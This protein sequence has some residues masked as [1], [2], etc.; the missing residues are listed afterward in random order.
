[1]SSFSIYE[2]TLTPIGNRVL[3]TD[4]EFGEQ[5][6][7][8]GIILPSDDGQTRGIH[9]RWGKVI[10][11]GPKN[12]DDYEIGEYVLVEHGRWTRGI[13]MKNG[14]KEPITIHMVEAESI[15]GTSKEK[16]KD[17]LSRRTDTENIHLAE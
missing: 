16:P 14:D 1:M 7:A 9:P 12:K 11:K 6:T 3:V 5:K 2:G 17:V 10:A 15:L 13:K 4:M 8:G